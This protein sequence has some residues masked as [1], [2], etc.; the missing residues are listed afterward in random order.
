KVKTKTRCA[1][2][3]PER[4]FV[5]FSR[6]GRCYIGAGF[7]VNYGPKLARVFSVPE[8]I[9]SLTFIALGTSLPELATSLTALKKK[10]SSLSLGNIIGADMLISCWWWSRQ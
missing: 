6:G 8:S 7:L 4:H 2:S 1:S 9:I 3:A 10:H 5:S